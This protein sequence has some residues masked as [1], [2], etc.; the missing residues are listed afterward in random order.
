M[1]LHGLEQQ[2]ALETATDTQQFRI[3]YRKTKD[4]GLFHG[5]RLNLSQKRGATEHQPASIDAA[6]P[7]RLVSNPDL[8]HFNPSARKPLPVSS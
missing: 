8:T 2:A 3:V 6:Q 4:P 7:A 5:H 1:I